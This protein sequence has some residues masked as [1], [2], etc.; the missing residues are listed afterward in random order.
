[1]FILKLQ[2][3]N[4]FVL[5]TRMKMLILKFIYDEMIENDENVR[6]KKMQLF[7]PIS[8][9]NKNHLGHSNHIGTEPFPMMVHRSSNCHRFVNHIFYTCASG[10]QDCKDFRCNDHILPHRIRMLSALLDSTF[11]N[12][13][14]LLSYLFWTEIKSNQNK[15]KKN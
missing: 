5:Q 12:S 3:K 6:N 1:M 11:R 15:R 13:H 7:L 4:Y 9:S 14:V 8:R 10:V 2:F